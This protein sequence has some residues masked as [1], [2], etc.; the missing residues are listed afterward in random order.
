VRKN[1]APRLARASMAATLNANTTC[2]GTPTAMIQSV[3][4]IAGQ[5]CGSLPNM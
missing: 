3:F 1:P 2:N 5:T 4:L